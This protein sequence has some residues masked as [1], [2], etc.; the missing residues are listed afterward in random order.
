MAMKR[1]SVLAVLV[2]LALAV[3]P[4]AVAADGSCTGPATAVVLGDGASHACEGEIR[5]PVRHRVP[6]RV[7]ARA[8]A[9]GAVL[10]GVA[11]RI[12]D[13]RIASCSFTP[14]TCSARGSGSIRVGDIVTIGCGLYDAVAV[15]A[16]VTCWWSV[17]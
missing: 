9:T 10:M 4:P 8:R 2:V 5:C 1:M 3:A 14:F 11:V 16:T 7:I 13:E 12:D 17:R 6:C 15:E